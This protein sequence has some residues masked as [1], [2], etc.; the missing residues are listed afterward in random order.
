MYNNTH[1]S[2]AW[3]YSPTRFSNQYFILLT[4]EKWTKKKW[5]GPEQYE[6]PDGDLMM[7]PTD[8]ALIW[9]PGFKKYVEV[10]AKDKQA[11]YNDFSKAFSKLLELGVPRSKF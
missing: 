6:N 1:T 11:F 3:T 10:Y 4:K 7:L 9:D 5:S 2:I 8:M